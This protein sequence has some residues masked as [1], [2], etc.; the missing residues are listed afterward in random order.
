MIGVLQ[1]VHSH[2]VRFRDRSECLATCDDVRVP[3][4]RMRWRPRFGGRRSCRRRTFSDHYARAHVCDLLFQFEDL[5]R[6][7]VNLGV[8]FLYLFRQRFKLSIII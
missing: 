5:L 6:K 2:F 8:L 4:G 7:R 1:F 3:A